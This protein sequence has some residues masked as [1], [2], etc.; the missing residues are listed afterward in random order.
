MRVID[1][2][3]RD[4]LLV[5]IK[6][7]KSRVAELERAQISRRIA[8]EEHPATIEACMEN[9][10]EAVVLTTAP[11][12]LVRLI[13]RYAL[14][15]FEKTRA[16]IE[17]LP[18]SMVFDGWTMHDQDGRVIGMDECPAITA[19]RQGISTKDKEIV[20]RKDGR[21]KAVL[22]NAAPIVDSSGRIIGS[23]TAWREITERRRA[24]EELRNEKDLLRQIMEI[25]P[26]GVWL[27]DSSGWIT[28]VNRAARKIW[29]GAR[30]VGIERYAEYKAWRP[31]S[32]APLKAED[33]PAYKALKKGTT[34]I[35]EELEISSFDGRRRTILCSAKPIRRGR[36][37]AGAIFVNQDITARKQAEKA[38]RR[39]E[40]MLS[41]AQKLANLGSWEWD[42]GTDTFTG[43]EEAYNIFGLEPGTPLPRERFMEMVHEED[44]ALVAR[45]IEDGLKGDH[46]KIQ[47][48][49]STLGKQL[50]YLEG[51]GKVELDNHRGPVMRGTVQDITDT[52]ERELERER[53]FDDL[54]EALAR[55]KT[56][57]GLI[58]ICANCKRIR[59]D[60][61][62]WRRIERY[63][64]ERSQAEFTH[65]L[66]PECEETLYGEEARREK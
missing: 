49:I 11:D 62:Y 53:L 59:D 51:I 34:A 5:V 6:G 65:S 57:S 44:R 3:S 28:D 43:S 13:S 55:I 58:P 56:L 7:L 18:V 46:Y 64:E 15:F 35:E 37:I 50:K 66:C 14:E 31:E 10:P 25:M 26:V 1:E 23:M 24:E 47:F 21:E 42:I 16:D 22:V 52:K 61:G 60:R 54:R 9:L 40:R 27:I 39:S 19:L 38:L 29:G 12:G 2:M 8:L 33:W 32:G 4:E 30:H 45:A 48:R 20:I 41:E 17:G 36:S 63:I